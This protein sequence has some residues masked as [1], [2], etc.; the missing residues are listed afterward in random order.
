MEPCKILVVAGPTASG[1][2][3]LGVE[4]CKRF[5]GEVVSGDSMQV[6]RQLSVATAKPTAEE[7]QGIPHHLIDCLDITQPF[8]VAEYVRSAGE[9]I[10]DILERGRLPIVVG[11]TGLYIH[12]LVDHIRYAETP[13]D[14]T[15]REHLRE[16]AQ[17]E[18]G[19]AMLEELRL[20]DPETAS[21][22]HPHDIG[23][24]IRA[25]EV[26]RLTGGTIAEQKILSRQEPSPYLPFW[27]GLD[28]ADRQLLYDRI[29]RRV[30]RMV[31]QGLVEEAAALLRGE[32]APTAAQA[33]GCKELAPYLEQQCTL[34]EALDHLKRQTRRYAKR[35]LSWF[36]REPNMHWYLV[37]QLGGMEQLIR[38]IKNDMEINGFL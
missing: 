18:G 29:N 14:P 33:I 1:K 6:Y 9:A 23:R 8:S 19:E 12:S 26:A 5:D 30:D 21:R 34:E 4:L 13:S 32:G 10:Q 3:A 20:V 11:G 25:L 31:E 17:A 27:I 7:M 24:I 38:K 22:L 16:R 37:D 15:L 2:T 35:Q 36:R 28:F